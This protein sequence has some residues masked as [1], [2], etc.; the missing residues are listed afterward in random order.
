MT[1]AGRLMSLE[2]TENVEENVID[3]DDGEPEVEYPEDARCPPHPEIAALSKIL[4]LQGR[5]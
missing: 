3:E 1:S 2:S 5:V 4:P